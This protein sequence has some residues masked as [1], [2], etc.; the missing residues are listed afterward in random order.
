M[1]LDYSYIQQVFVERYTITQGE[2]PSPVEAVLERV[3]VTN[4][5]DHKR[6][7]QA[8]LMGANLDRHTQGI[9]VAKYTVEVY[10]TF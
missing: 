4:F 10:E 6:R 9:R 2:R 8:V 5:P 3:D 7:T 1:A